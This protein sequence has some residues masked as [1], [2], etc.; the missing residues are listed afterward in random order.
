ML[1]GDETYVI[2]P[3]SL[4]IFMLLLVSVAGA[5]L[6]FYFCWFMWREHSASLDPSLSQCYSAMPLVSL[7]FQVLAKN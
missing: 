1:S 3:R 6:Y 4:Y 7:R 5:M 2:L